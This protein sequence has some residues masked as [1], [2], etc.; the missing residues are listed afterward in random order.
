MPL[1][2]LV[3]LIFRSEE[4]LSDYFRKSPSVFRNIILLYLSVLQQYLPYVQ[5]YYSTMDSISLHVSPRPLRVSSHRTSLSVVAAKP[6]VLPVHHDFL[7]AP[8]IR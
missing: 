8:S 1:K 5:P 2:E 7:S 4:L 3:S 6:L